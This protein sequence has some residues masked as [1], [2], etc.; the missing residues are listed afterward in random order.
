MVHLQAKSKSKWEAKP[1]VAR[2]SEKSTAERC[3]RGSEVLIVKDK[4]SR[5]LSIPPAYLQEAQQAQQV[6]VLPEK[7]NHLT[8]GDIVHINPTTGHIWVM[9]KQSSQFN[10]IF[11]TERCNNNCIMCSQPPH[12]IKDEHICNVYLEAIP[13][14]NQ[15]TV[16][17]GITGGEPT[18]LGSE[19][20]DVIRLCKEHL[21]RTALH[22]LSNGRMFNYLSF[23]QE[24]HSIDHP[25]LMIGI[26][27]YSDIPGLHDYIVQTK[28]AY[29]QTIRGLLNLARLGTKLEIRVVLHRQTIPRIHS[30]A[31]FISRNL[32]FVNHIA[33]M[34][35]E[36]MGYARKNINSLWIDP[37]EYNDELKAAVY[38]LNRN[39]LNVSI[40][41]H[42]LCILDPELWHLACK[43][44]SDWKNEYFIECDSCSVKS[45][46]GGFFSSSKNKHSNYIKPIV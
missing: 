34:G 39:R 3:E 30:L 43:S 24:I 2:V 41:N 9:Y 12:N 6:I 10:A 16:S 40:Y 38:E 44:I 20:I 32:P 35:M 17:L 5:Y 45:N 37:Y 19:F 28:G 31:K 18:L 36:I 15:E 23:C 11:I 29:D 22:V 33:F 27:L 25:D 42:Q 21:P 26:P 8:D 46:C 1:F 4:Q 7:L 13:L 14:M